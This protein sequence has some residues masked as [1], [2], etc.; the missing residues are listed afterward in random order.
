MKL[1]YDVLDLF[2]GAGGLSLG[3]KMAGFDIVGGIDFDQEALDTHKLNFKEGY[4]YCGDISELDDEFVLDNF[5]GKVDVIIG[6]PPCQGFSV[7]NMQQKDIECDDRNKLFYEFIRFVRLLK[8]KAFVMENVPQILTKDKGHVKKVMMEVM[9]ELGYNVNVKVLLASDYGVP[10]RRRRAFFVGLDKSFKKTFDFNNIE[11][12]PKVTVANAISD[13]YGFDDETKSSTVDDEF[14]LDAEANCDYQ[15]LMRK[16]SNGILHN[17]NIRYP[18]EIVQTRMEHV[19]EGGNWKDVP[20]ELWDTVRS[21]RHSS[22]YRRLDTRDVSV[23]IDTGHMNYF[24][25]KYNRVPTVR[26]SARIQSFPDD[27]IFTGGQGAQ[28][29]QVGNAVPPL[30]SCAIATTLKSYLNG[31]ENSLEKYI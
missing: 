13:L 18:K 24:H 15:K 3:F 6:G 16:G 30:L 8:P 31:T 22:A 27:F 1:K 17:H 19:P 9:D 5:D 21:N 10:Q 26:E 23:T 2:C 4:H 14:D 20:E 29:R 11:K 25:P 7:A 28:F 12:K